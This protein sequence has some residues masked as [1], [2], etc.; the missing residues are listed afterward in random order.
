MMTDVIVI[1]GG[2]AGMFAAITAARNGCKVLLFERNDRLGK[3]LLITGKGRC[4][5]TNDC[6]AQEV[7]QNI[8]RNGRFLYSA[9]AAF[10]PKSAVAFFESHGCQLKTERG[11]RVFPLSDKAISVLD[12]LRQEMNRLHV[13]V[14]NERVR[15]ILAV[16][17]SVSG[18]ETERETYSAT[19]VILST[20][21]LSY[22]T[23]GSTGDG[24]EMARTLGHTIVP[25]EGSLVPLETAGSDCQDMQGLSL[26]NVAVKLV[27]GGK[28][29]CAAPPMKGGIDHSFSAVREMRIAPDG[30]LESELLW[31]SNSRGVYL[32]LPNNGMSIE[33]DGATVVSA[34]AWGQFSPV[35]EVSVKVGDSEPVALK[36]VGGSWIGEIKEK[37]LA[38]KA[39]TVIGKRRKSSALS[40]TYQPQERA[41]E[42]SVKLC[43]M[44]NQPENRSSLQNFPAEKRW[45]LPNLIRNWQLWIKRFL[46]PKQSGKPGRWNWKLSGRK[47][48]G[49]MHSKNVF[50]LT[51]P[52]KC[53][54]KYKERCLKSPVFYFC[55]Y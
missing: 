24:Y 49:S 45:I 39:I 4:N 31:G 44:S 40:R 19:K 38:G 32:T 25:T 10:P 34:T 55:C 3:K 13:I 42:K 22:P 29:Y 8:P 54:I 30:T 35:L 2:P 52:L 15:R 5:V 6:D 1:G 7:L 43:W 17:G 18:V 23:T 12:C 37:D 28:Y 9:M 47:M 11:N 48:T 53:G 14:R 21:G 36:K 33:K 46:K 26:R 50:I 41:A 27:N 20:G 16:D 51:T